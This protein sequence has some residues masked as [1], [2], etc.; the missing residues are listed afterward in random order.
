MATTKRAQVTALDSCIIIETVMVP[1]H[2]IAYV[3]SYA[4]TTGE[5]GVTV[6]LKQGPLGAVSVPGYTVAG[7]AQLYNGHPF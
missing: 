2:N 7:F 5:S 4:M 6:H 1:H 3:S